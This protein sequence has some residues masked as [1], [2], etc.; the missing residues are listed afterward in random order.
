M[1]AAKESSNEAYLMRKNTIVGKKHI[2]N[3]AIWNSSKNTNKRG[4]LSMTNDKRLNSKPF[5]N[6]REN[7][8]AKVFKSINSLKKTN[9]TGKSTVLESI[10]RRTSMY[11]KI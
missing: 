7:K 6:K 4:L 11:F 8:T 2:S 10:E 5:E 3:I 1:S 9:F